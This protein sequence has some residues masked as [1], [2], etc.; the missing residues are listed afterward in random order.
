M[1]SMNHTEKL[2]FT[3]GLTAQD[4]V[5]IGAHRDALSQ[6]VETQRTTYG[7]WFT[8]RMGWDLK[9]GEPL[10]PG[11]LESYTRGEY[12]DD[13]CALQYQQ[14]LRWYQAGMDA[15]EALAAQ[16]EM[17]HIL[18]AVAQDILNDAA[19]ARA[20]CRVVDLSQ[21]VQTLV[22]HVAH[23]LDRLRRSAELD[24]ARLRE[25]CDELGTPF[26]PAHLVRAYSEHYQW[27]IKAYG[28]AL[29][30]NSQDNVLCLGP[31]ECALGR[32]LVDGGTDEI[33]EDKRQGF[34]SAH[35]RLHQMGKLVL[36]EARANRP[37]N[38]VE[39]L[40]DMEAASE[41]VIGVLQ[42]RMDC[43]LR[44]LAAEDSLTRL[45]NRRLFE[46]DL[47]RRTAESD[48]IAKGLGLLFID[49]DHFKAVNDRYGHAVG[50]EVL[51]GAAGRVVEVLRAADSVYRWGGEEFAAMIFVEGIDELRQAAER[52]R[53]SF[54]ATPYFTSHGLVDVTTSIGGTYYPPGSAI[55]PT[56]L[57]TRADRF[58]YEAK[59]AGRNRSIVH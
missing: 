51:R 27:K 14:A 10:L 55:S 16:S 45:G 1:P 23:T 49:L 43:E 4:D 40:L 50:D 13:F 48:R 24:L 32:W 54:E 28:L 26:E 35:E 41:E 44:Q 6:A 53:A 42:H 5:L 29:G 33:P 15:R 20:L 34:L 31:S 56:E 39:S 36:H 17:R 25:P 47:Q 2:R 52:V 21:A 7:E 12:Q 46:R 9:R 37:Y 19:M 8:K 22:F 3:V 11:V 18:I 57:F 38:I 58:M 59:R 30:E